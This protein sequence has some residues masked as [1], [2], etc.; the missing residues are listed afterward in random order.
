[1]EIEFTATG[2]ETGVI[3]GDA[4][5]GAGSK[6]DVGHA[7]LD[8]GSNTEGRKSDQGSNASG[9]NW[10]VHGECRLIMFLMNVNGMFGSESG[11]LGIALR[12]LEVEVGLKKREEEMGS[13]RNRFQ[14]L[15]VEKF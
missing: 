6:L 15:I 1:M 3:P 7:G 8:R 2:T 11:R 14:V 10:G 12:F 13:G 5:R 4:A 9:D